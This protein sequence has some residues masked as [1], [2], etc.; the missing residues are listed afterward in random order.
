MSSVFG[1][2]PDLLFCDPGASGISGRRRGLQD[3]KKSIRSGRVHS[4]IVVDLERLYR[5]MARMVMFLELLRE[6]DVRLHCISN[7]G[8]RDTILLL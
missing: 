4:V 5:D 7:G 3:L 8:P 6:C 1:V 2:E